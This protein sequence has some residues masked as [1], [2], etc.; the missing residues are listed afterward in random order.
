MLVAGIRM[1][2]KYSECGAGFSTTWQKRLGATL[3]ESPCACTY[4]GEYREEDANFEPCFP[5]S[6]RI[7]IEGI[8]IREL[9]GAMW[10]VTRA[11]G[12][13][14]SI[15]PQLRKAFETGEMNKKSE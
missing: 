10:L 13:L 2:G 15:R 3:R 6:K 5:I 12:A 14:R 1:K 11:S 7:E 4:D 8:S 9:P